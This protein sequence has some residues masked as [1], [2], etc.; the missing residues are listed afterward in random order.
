MTHY[1]VAQLLNFIICP[2]LGAIVYFKNT[3]SLSNK[4]FALYNLVIA[5]WCFGFFKMA[6]SQNATQG[7]FWARELHV[8]AI[9]LPVFL[10]H[11]IL[12]LLGDEQKE[13]VIIRIAYIIAV[14]M[15]GFIPTNLF[16]SHT[17]S[18]VGIKYFVG[19]AGIQ[20]HLFTAFFFIC[21]V[22][23]FY[24]LYGGF[25][26]YKDNDLRRN[27][28]KYLFYALVIIYA[29]GSTAFL[30]LFKIP[31]PKFAL[32]SI[33]IYSLI[34][35]YTIIHYRLMDINL[36][37][38][39]GMAYLIY[40]AVISG[41][42]TLGIS[43]FFI[44]DITIVLTII[45]CIAITP[46][47]Y[48]FMMENLLHPFILKTLRQ[49]L[50]KIDQL[51]HS[52]K[53][54]NTTKSFATSLATDLYNIFKLKKIFFLCFKREQDKFVLIYQKPNTDELENKEFSFDSPLIKYFIKNKTFIHKPALHHKHNGEKKELLD[55]MNKLEIELG[56]PFFNGEELLLVLCLG[57][58]TDKSLFHEEEV[59][60]LA[61]LVQTKEQSFAWTYFAENQ[62]HLELLAR[63]IMESKDLPEVSELL[64]KGSMRHLNALYGAMYVYD[65]DTSTYLCKY[66]QGAKKGYCEDLLENDCLIKFLQDRQQYL[67]TKDVERWAT[68]TKGKD[69]KDT[70]VILKKLNAEIV[71]PI[72]S[73]KL[74]L[75]F[76]VLGLKR[77]QGMYT[78]NDIAESNSLVRVSALTIK[79]MVLEEESQRD[80]LTKA[81]NRKK[82]LDWMYE[83]ILQCKKEVK[84]C[85]FLSFDI[86]F[87]KKLN[88]DKG[89]EQGDKVLIELVKCISKML[90]P[91]DMIFRMGG[92]EF[93]I[94]LFGATK[95]G[96]YKFCE[97]LSAEMKKGK[98][99]QNVTLSIGLVVFTPD[100]EYEEDDKLTSNIK[101][102]QR[103][104]LDTG[105]SAVYQA[106]EDGRNRVQEAKE[107]KDT[108]VL[109][110]Y[111]PKCQIITDNK[112]EGLKISNFFL[113]HEFDAK[114]SIW[115]KAVED[116]EQDRSDVVVFGINE[117]LNITKVIDTIQEIK[118]RRISAMIGVII[119]DL[120][121][122][123]KLKELRIDRYFIGELDESI[124]DWA[125][126]LARE[127][128]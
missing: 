31:I 29:G 112:K 45:T 98:N 7:L 101:S 105:D 87:F 57:E 11:F 121:I 64:V 107:I 9:L 40:V 37:L 26:K 54:F 47:I 109:E 14:I 110:Q 8:G 80:P 1:A 114:M 35:A 43:L 78:E 71:F 44:L 119:S 128:K 20:Y 116:F 82:L 22:Y 118:K 42:I 55:I 69:M 34:I 111:S 19:P 51:T 13:K 115:K 77:T 103:I 50:K 30:P 38:K 23:S 127:M 39:K 91:E 49:E 48:K 58:K 10:L 92:E 96:G 89:H 41:L 97:R 90:K 72:L 83:I 125:K 95:D 27:Q 18:V 28:L 32:Y 122:K 100:K 53:I 2:I 108:E 85:V 68:E 67:L 84:S 4:I 33:S 24:K 88:D 5:A 46:F 75:G 70:L 124:E 117:K 15:L 66:T 120:K 36:A 76:V 12:A 63:K 61:N 16:V 102:I 73:G 17:V 123:E 94:V 113:A 93:F 52:N 106:K 126:A 25:K 65:I 99:I 59:K 21:L 6:T 56:F 74:F 62:K 86:D 104:V 3:K 60:K 79:T 81:Y